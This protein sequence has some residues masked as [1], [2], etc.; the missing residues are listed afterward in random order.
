MEIKPFK[1]FPGL[2][3]VELLWLSLFLFGVVVFVLWY[4]FFK[5]VFLKEQATALLKVSVYFKGL[6]FILVGRDF[7]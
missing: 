2:G 5:N 3:F 7:L 6:R 4:Y 1:S